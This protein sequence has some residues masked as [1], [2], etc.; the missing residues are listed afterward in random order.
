MQAGGAL[1]GQ[2]R[3]EGPCPQRALSRT[4]CCRPGKPGLAK[5]KMRWVK[6]PQQE[7]QR[8]PRATVPD[9]RVNLLRAPGLGPGA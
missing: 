9:T 2:C 6:P 1:T 4:C 8:G 5:G 3:R 7:G